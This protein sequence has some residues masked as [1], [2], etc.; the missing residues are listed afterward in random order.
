MFIIDWPDID[1]AKKLDEEL[2]LSGCQIEAKRLSNTMLAFLF[3]HLFA[4]FLTFYRENFEVKLGEVGR[5]MRFIEV[6]GVMIYVA[7]ITDAF[8]NY[9][10]YL[11]FG[12]V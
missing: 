11:M 9:G 7:L 6:M 12:H 3:F 1:R 8:T 2:N 10:I 5:M 4:T